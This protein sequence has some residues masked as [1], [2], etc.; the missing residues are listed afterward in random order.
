VERSDPDKVYIIYDIPDRHSY[1]DVAMV[2]FGPGADHIH[3]W[4]CSYPKDTE[5]RLAAEPTYWSYGTPSDKN[6]SEWHPRS[7][8]CANCNLPVIDLHY[9]CTECR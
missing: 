7:N 2:W 6:Y 8:P 4:L 5:P 3:T 9:L 1:E